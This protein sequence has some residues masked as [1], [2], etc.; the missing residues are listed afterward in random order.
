MT[1][2]SDTPRTI[3]Q[4]PN[5]D[6]G[7]E[8]DHGDLVNDIFGGDDGDEDDGMDMDMEMEMDVEGETESEKPSQTPT[9]PIPFPVVQP[10]PVTVGA[11]VKSN[12]LENRNGFGSYGPIKVDSFR[13]GLAG[14]PKATPSRTPTS[15]G[16][17]SPDT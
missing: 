2:S 10:L 16:D 12:G 1:S 6:D 15:G 4:T 7:E 14:F 11:T 9:T 3:L 13:P 8:G 17:P 5:G